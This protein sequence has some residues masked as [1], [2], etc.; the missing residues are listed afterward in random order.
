[1]KDLLVVIYVMVTSPVFL[2][3]LIAMTWIWIIEK[4]KEAKNYGKTR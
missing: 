1:M 3:W 4:N 2:G